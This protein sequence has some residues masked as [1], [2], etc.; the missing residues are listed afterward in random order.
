MS[1]TSLD[2]ALDALDGAGTATIDGDGHQAEVDVT[3]VDR[4]GVKIREVRVRHDAPRDIVEEAHAL[5]D[6]LRALPEKVQPIEVAPSLGGA[7]LRSQPRGDHGE[8]YEVDLETDS[9]T[10]R[11]TARGD[12]G[13]RQAQDFTLTREQLD[14]LL[15]QAAG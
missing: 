8:M 1:R 6:R 10:I 3:D 11:R 12:D 4:L 13:G 2:D 5:P 14:R 7:R 15:E 9:T